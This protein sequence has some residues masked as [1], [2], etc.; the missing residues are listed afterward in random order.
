MRDLRS[1]AQSTTRRLILGGLVLVFAVGDGLV[2]LI[3]GDQAGRTAL[4]CT[5]IGLGPVLL[6]LVALEAMAWVVRKTDEG[7][8]S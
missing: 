1:Y 2:W 4:I 8:L 3:Y 7:E 5:A 6:I